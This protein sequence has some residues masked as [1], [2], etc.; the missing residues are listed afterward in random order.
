MFPCRPMS[1]PCCPAL[2][3]VLMPWHFGLAVCLGLM[4]VGLAEP[5]GIA[6][7]AKPKPSP[8]S[9]CAARPPEQVLASFV[10]PA[11]ISFYVFPRPSRDTGRGIHWVP[12]GAQEPAVVDRLLAEARAMH[13]SWLTISSDE[14][15]IGPND[16]LVR[17]AV[18][19][20]I[21]PVMRV[22]TPNGR[23]IEGDLAE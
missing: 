14:A 12:T 9:P 23:P 19:S 17:K 6:V 2:R 16:Y 7:A 18:A 21:E 13:I 3:R 5:A 20:Q 4:L 8:L 15:A 1:R 22:Y 11:P 10:P